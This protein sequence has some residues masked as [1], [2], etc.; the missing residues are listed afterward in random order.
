LTGAQSI[1]DDPARSRFEL[2]QG[3]VTIGYLT[4]QPGAQGVVALLHAEVD[5]AHRGSG[6]GGRLVAQ[7]LHLLRERGVS[8]LPFCPFVR[9]YLAGHPGEEDLVPVAQRERFG[10]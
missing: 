6:V 5:P 2:R 3:E 9:A 10:L 1:R 4:Y 8:V 7:S